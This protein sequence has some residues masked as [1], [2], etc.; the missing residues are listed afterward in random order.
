MIYGVFVFS[1][2]PGLE[3]AGQ[4]L[5]HALDSVQCVVCR[6]QYSG[7]SIK[8]SVQCSAVCN[9]SVHCSTK[10][11]VSSTFEYAL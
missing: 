3:E 2:P 7:L 9:V 1:L 6:V 4:K 5:L 10:C 11:T 8:A